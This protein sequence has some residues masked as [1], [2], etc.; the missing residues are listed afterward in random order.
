MLGKEETPGEGFYLPHG[1][2]VGRKKE[3]T[4][5]KD[6]LKNLDSPRF[7]SVTGSSGV[8]CSALCER[9]LLEAGYEGLATAEIFEGHSLISGIL[10]SFMSKDYRKTL[11]KRLPPLME[12]LSEDFPQ[13]FLD[14]L[15]IPPKPSPSTLAGLNSNI[16]GFIEELS[17]A[18][19]IIA[20][21][22]TTPNNSLIEEIKK[23]GAKILFLFDKINL[24]DIHIDLSPLDEVE[25]LD[26]IRGLL[27]PVDDIDTLSSSVFKVANGNPY[28]IRKTIR[29]FVSY[30]ALE[31]HT[32]TWHFS[33]ERT[34]RT[35]SFSDKWARL[36]EDAKTI[37]TAICLAGELE[38]SILEDMI[39]P[40]SSFAVYKI[41][42]AGLIGERDRSGKNLFFAYPELASNIDSIISI[43][44]AKS[45]H[46]RLADAFIR[47]TP[48]FSNRISSAYHFELAGQPKT[49]AEMFFEIGTKAL[50]KT[51]FNIA[52]RALESANRLSEHLDT[53]IK[54]LRCLKRLALTRK[55]AGDFDSARDAYFQASA[56]A[57]SMGNS[58]QKASVSGDIGVTYFE[59]GNTKL[60]LKYYKKALKLH[61]SAKNEKGELI[62]LV[63]I[64]GLY[65]VTSNLELAKN[66]YTEALKKA[67]K[68]NNKLCLSAVNLNLGEMAIAEADLASALKLVLESGTIARD[69]GYDNMLF[70]A[71][72]ALSKVHRLQGHLTLARRSIEE[73]CEITSFEGG[74]ESAIAG[75]ERAAIARTVGE[76]PIAKAALKNSADFYNY[77][78][79]TEKARLFE[80]IAILSALEEVEPLSVPRVEL[81]EKTSLFFQA[82]AFIRKNNL[83]SALSLIE[84]SIAKQPTAL[85]EIEIEHYIQKAL[86]LYRLERFKQA[87]ETLELIEQSLNGINP[88]MTARVSA[89]RCQILDKLDNINSAKVALSSAQ[90]RF[91]ALENWTELKKLDAL[92][93][94]LS[95]PK[96]KDLSFSKMLP[97]LK[98]LNST[99]DSAHLLRKILEAT[100]DATGAE[101][102]L[103]FLMENGSAELRIAISANGTD[104]PLDSTK[105]SHGLLENVMASREAHFSE[106][107]ADDDALSTRESIIDLDITMAM[108]VPVTGLNSELVG[109]IYADAGIGKGLFD[110]QTLDFLTALG[111]QAAIALHNAELFDDLRAERDGMAREI[112]VFG[113]GKIIGTSP[114]MLEL[115]QKLN[116]V[117]GQ[118][119]S[120]LI[121]GETGTGK[122]LIA[123]TLHAES[124]RS[125]GPFVAINCAAIPE[126]LIESE[127][128]GHERGAFTGADRKQIGKFELANGGILFLDEIAEMP[129]AFQ[130]KLLRAIESREIHRLGANNEI[131]VDVRIISATNLN[132]EFALKNQKLRED[133]YYRIAP[134]NIHIP[135]LREHPEDIP[136]L[137]LH[138]LDR[139]QAKFGRNIESVTNSALSALKRYPWPGNVRELIGTLE[140]A[141]IFSRTNIL[142][143]EDFPPRIV[144][145][146]PLDSNSSPLPKN[147]AQLQAMKKDL[148]EG[149]EREVLLKILETHNWKVTK[150]AKA[151][152]M[153]RSRLHHLISYYGFKK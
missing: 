42:S 132:I 66:I 137:I 63:N 116:I 144:K 49:S 118:D 112:C 51:N 97:I 10:P 61:S 150:A 88:W 5:I 60:A 52:E 104:L 142:R 14:D 107:I 126:N 33:I 117:A 92:L 12:F 129:I 73:A 34:D 26:L 111:E 65:Q 120:L 37:C 124:K 127:L 93:A 45:V 68:L 64:G 54:K 134:I 108:C 141:L 7:V 24:G 55:Y 119:I 50:K 109:L 72:I 46:L 147:Y 13:T 84:D 96:E 143:A 31:T 128:F 15:K 6:I 48:N 76:Y 100:L 78:G 146:N 3:L 136:L 98:A 135:P 121:T 23:T 11:L 58:E 123:R 25:T 130:V 95:E 87:L 2:F 102:A 53:P 106:S 30:G 56:M 70:Q 62:D 151:F 125:E 114:A 28:T 110:R 140:E 39:G 105:F 41:L 82:L 79:S 44:R 29:E 35:T 43:E 47:A 145:F 139:A 131:P 67:Q 86:I 103:L 18:K 122:D 89:L 74:R 99:L 71:L 85:G 21:I 83:D 17:F 27:G 19:P 91:K 115:K 80:E 94:K 1:P 8:G 138:Y 36:I 9:A 38:Y 77:L 20:H 75:I 153:N 101:R 148:A 32:R 113:E 22:R 133:L 59:Q 4:Q 152:K 16:A 57:E 90:S 69:K 149:Y 40:G 81:P